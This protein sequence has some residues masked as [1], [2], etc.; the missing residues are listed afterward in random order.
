MFGGR[1]VVQACGTGARLLS[2]GDGRRGRNGRCS[3][4]KLPSLTGTS[5]A[6]FLS[7]DE[8]FND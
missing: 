1:A 5:D 3:L 8:F 2:Q 4:R 7:F 6:V